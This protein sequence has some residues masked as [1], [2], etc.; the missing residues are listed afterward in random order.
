[1]AVVK[2]DNAH[3]C[4]GQM[5]YTGSLAA[6]THNPPV[7]GSSPTRPTACELGL[8]ASSCACGCSGMGGRW[9]GYGRIA[10]RVGVMPPGRESRAARAAG[11]SDEGGTPDLAGGVGE[12]GSAGDRGARALGDN[13]IGTEHILLALTG[14]ADGG[15]AEVLA[16]FGAD[17]VVIRQ[18]VIIQVQAEGKQP[19]G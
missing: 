2:I 6:W 3:V 1:M 4:P 15:V 17:P 8:C 5:P 14:E 13:H 12:A 16:R 10:L 19:S 7:V 11:L 18:Q 9:P